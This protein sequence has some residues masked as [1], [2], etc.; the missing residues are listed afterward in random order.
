MPQWSGQQLRSARH[1]GERGKGVAPRACCARGRL[2]RGSTQCQM[3]EHVGHIIDVHT[4]DGDAVADGERTSVSTA[5]PERTFGTRTGISTPLALFTAHGA[6][7]GSSCAPYRPCVASTLGSLQTLMTNT[8]HSPVP[9]LRPPLL[10]CVALARSLVDDPAAHVSARP[11]FV[12]AAAR[13]TDSLAHTCVHP[14][15]NEELQDR[16]SCW[17]RGEVLFEAFRDGLH[18]RLATPRC[19]TVVG[20]MAS[21]RSA[22][23]PG[24]VRGR[25]SIYSRRWKQSSLART[26]RRW[27]LVSLCRSSMRGVGYG[28]PKTRAAEAEGSDSIVWEGSFASSFPLSFPQPVGPSTLPS[29]FVTC[30]LILPLCLPPPRTHSSSGAYSGGIV[31]KGR[32]LACSLPLMFSRSCV[33]S[34]WT[35]EGMT[36]DDPLGRHLQTRPRGTTQGVRRGPR[37]SS[38]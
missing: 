36:L 20:A 15:G 23:P 13:F 18:R 31:A 2:R 28:P 32:A 7:F 5:S 17:S 25:R 30:V 16:W 22:S 4:M 35:V 26:H 33:R 6:R 34:L 21:G 27:V 10:H 24:D 9:L 12:C 11:R 38:S 29:L 3:L 8:C 37:S 1:R 19:C 14:S